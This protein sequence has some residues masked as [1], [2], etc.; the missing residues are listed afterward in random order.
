LRTAG[1][2]WLLVKLSQSPALLLH[3]HAGP[4]RLLVAGH[5]HQELPIH[6]LDALPTELLAVGVQGQDP[7]AVGVFAFDPLD[8]L[9]VAIQDDQLE[10]IVVGQADAQ[11][12]RAFAVRASGGRC[13]RCGDLLADPSNWH[14]HHRHRRVYGGGSEVSNRELLHPHCYRQLHHQGVGNEGAASCE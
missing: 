3:L 12:A 1:W 6:R 11:G 10:R 14:L 7:V 4:G 5:G 8:D 13:R 9:L 2:P